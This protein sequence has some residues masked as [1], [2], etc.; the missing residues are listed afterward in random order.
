M[1]KKLLQSIDTNFMLMP[2]Y[3][4]YHAHQSHVRKKKNL[5][6]RKKTFKHKRNIISQRI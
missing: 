2:I 1:Q 3:F 5:R 4:W 6:K